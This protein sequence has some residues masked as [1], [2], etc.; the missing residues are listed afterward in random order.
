[1][2]ASSQ[3]SRRFKK[4]GILLLP[5]VLIGILWAC[6]GEEDAGVQDPQF[7][8]CIKVTDELNKYSSDLLKREATA[9]DVVKMK[10]LRDARQKECSRYFQM[11]G[12][13]MKKRKKSC[14]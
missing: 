7:C 10:E 11:S 6:S 14:K 5:L 4:A 9:E 1:M 8:K 2:Q 12:D 3:S 13:E